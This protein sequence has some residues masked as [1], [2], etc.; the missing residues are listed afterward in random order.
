ME[1]TKIL[2]KQALKLSFPPLKHNLEGI[3]LHLPLQLRGDNGTIQKI[4]S[5]TLI[6]FVTSAVLTSQSSYHIDVQ[7]EAFELPAWVPQKL[8]GV[9]KKSPWMHW[10]CSTIT[11]TDGVSALPEHKLAETQGVLKEKPSVNNRSRGS[12]TLQRQWFVAYCPKDFFT[13]NNPQKN[14]HFC[15]IV[16]DCKRSISH[17]SFRFS[18]ARGSVLLRHTCECCGC[19]SNLLLVVRA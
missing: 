3:I 8:T 13:C 4:Q 11:V 19:H 2:P 18:W 15:F 17:I 6:A 7:F 9:I 10:R 14:L 16:L 12:H 5:G 1:H